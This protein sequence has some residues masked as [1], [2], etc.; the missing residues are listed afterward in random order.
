MKVCRNFGIFMYTNNWMNGRKN[1]WWIAIRRVSIWC[2]RRK[3][4]VSPIR[5]PCYTK[6]YSF[7]TIRSVYTWAWIQPCAKSEQQLTTS[8]IK[9][10]IWINH[11]S[12]FIRSVQFGMERIVEKK[13][14]RHSNSTESLTSSIHICTVH[15]IQLLKF[16]PHFFPFYLPHLGRFSSH[17]QFHD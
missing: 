8:E 15:I 1:G 17:P 5:W 9:T 3:S 6:E 13:S 10:R 7:S 14:H 4:Y 11:V 2:N 12:L 16:W